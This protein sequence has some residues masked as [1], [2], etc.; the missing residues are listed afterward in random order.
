[1]IIHNNSDK[2][3]RCIF[4]RS[5]ITLTPN[6]S[7]ECEEGFNYI[8][9]SITDES[10]SVLQAKKSK[11]LKFL[12]FL[13]DPFKL[14]KEYHLTVVSS[15]TKEQLSDYRH[16]TLTTHSCYADIE[17]RTY[18]NFIKVASENVSIAADDMEILC[19]KEIISDFVNNNRKLICWQ[20]VWD[21][22][23]EPM[24]LE[25]IGYWAIYRLFSLWFE[26]KALSIVL[27]ILGLN[28]VVDSILFLFKRKKLLKRCNKFLDLLNNATIMNNLI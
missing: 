15:F 21:I 16:I 12:S 6:D 18:Y 24:F 5:V 14:I 7:F 28:I 8:K 1:M 10:Y 11:L 26:T 25:V 19:K 27:L 13:D 20:S 3:I 9:F 17:T 23:L 2:Y 4:D 22:I